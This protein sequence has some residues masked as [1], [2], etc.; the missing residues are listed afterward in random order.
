MVSVMEYIDMYVK[1]YRN[2]LWFNDTEQSYN[3][4]LL[5]HIYMIEI[6]GM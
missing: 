4:G 3:T 6:D 1:V 2:E 5:H